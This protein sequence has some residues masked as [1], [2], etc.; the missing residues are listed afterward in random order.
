MTSLGWARTVGPA[1]ARPTGARGRLGFALG[2][3]AAL[4]ASGAGSRASDVA[5]VR[6]TTPAVFRLPVAAGPF[7]RGSAHGDED[8]RPVRT[9]VLPAFAIDKT[10]VTRVAYAA[11]V[12]ARRCRPVPAEMAG[13]VGTDAL[14]PVTGV[15]WFD[16]RDFCAFAGGRLPSE[17]E[18]EKAARGTDGRE[19]PWGAEPACAR[20]NWGNFDGEGPCAAHNPGFPVAVG[21]YPEGASP[22]GVLDMA[23]NVWEWVADR[24]GEDPRR[25][26]VRGGS[27][28]S[29]FVPPRAPNRNAWA[30][31]YRDSDLGFRCV[32][33]RR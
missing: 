15:S 10:E 7:V 24:Y 12:R 2:I 14:V 22:Y 31:E 17:A 1:V 18:W 21:R 19:F 5:G 33:A 29:Y 28:C 27:C 23:G 30:P 6:A 25:R 11:C 20:A 13:P 4:A 9:E 8:E 26:V 16:A 3:G 32:A